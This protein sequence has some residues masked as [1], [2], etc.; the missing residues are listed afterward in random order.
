MNAVLSCGEL[1]E[2]MASDGLFAV[3]DVRERGE[4]NQCQ[5]SGATSLRRGQI[6]FRLAQLVPNRNIPIVLYDEGDARAPLGAATLLRLGYQQVAVL[7]GGLVAW[8]G[9]G[10]PTVSG[11]N[12]P[13]KA[14]GERV[15]HDRNIPELTAEELKTLKDVSSELV[16]LDVRTP[17]EYARFCIPG[18]NNVPG[19]DLIHWA[20]EL[21]QRSNATVVVNCAGRTRSIIGT[22]VL[23]RF[24]L[25]NVRA[26]K[27]GTMGWVLAG[28][29][30]ERNPA[31]KP[32]PAPAGS[33]IQAVALARQIAAEERL[34]WISA[35]EVAS[36]NLVDPLTYLIDVRSE[37]EYESGHVPRSISVP[38]GQAVQRADDFVAV[39]N[40][41]I[42]FV[43][44]QSARA[45]M[46]A[47]W[48]RQ[49]GFPNVFVL[50][51]G[52]EGWVQGGGKLESGMR[53][54]EPLGL[55]ATEQSVRAIDPESLNQ[56]MR[57]A[58][59]FLLDVGTSLDFETAHVPEARWI[60]RGWL[61]VKL[62]ELFPEHGQAIVLT[63]PDGQNSAFA[64][65]TLIDLGYTNVA[66]LTGGVAAWSAAGYATESGLAACLTEPNDVVL[67]PSI[68]GNK[69]DM[70]RYLDWET[71]LPH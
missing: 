63:C 30:L 71:N 70:Q 31:R 68:R 9:E 43:S 7:A 65:Q 58:S 69:E 41:R 17:E 25:T 34:S 3:F 50:Q 52:L 51:D 33:R 14:F 66:V 11:V 64:A 54:I 55:A 62:P 35:P 20:A 19:G 61:D 60:S 10:R 57:K 37:A 49:M 6:E 40:A 59:A 38:G 48:Y 1:S 36:A 56:R 28:L 13:S 18:G 4:F 46:A 23:R 32:L 47:Y 24:G 42:I 15:H 2:L 44:D 5:I 29:E 22:A 21:K 45:V 16:I 27:N 53:L 67:S 26:L 8:Q 39:R 12:V